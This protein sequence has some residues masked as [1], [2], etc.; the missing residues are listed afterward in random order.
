[1]KRELLRAYLIE[2]KSARDIAEDHGVSVPRVRA[3]L[4]EHGIHIPPD[5]IRDE[6]CEA[7]AWLGHGSFAGFHQ[8]YGFRSVNE[9]AQELGVSKSVL[10]R[11]HDLL[12]RYVEQEAEPRLPE[13]GS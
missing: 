9:Q 2:G 1:V 8:A 7:V 12:R 10:Q 13:R 4:A 11:I 5:K 6:V 3:A